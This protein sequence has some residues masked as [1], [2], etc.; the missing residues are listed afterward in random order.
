[1]VEQ[2]KTVFLQSLIVTIVIFTIGLVIGFAIE[3]SRIDRTEIALLNSEINLLD[4]QVRNLNIETFNVSCD[5]AIQS[6]FDFADRIYHEAR[7]L[8]EYDLS[9]KFTNEL[10]VIHKKYDLLR[11]ILWAHTIETKEMCPHRYHTIVYLF[12]YN[13]ENINQKARQAAMSRLLLDLKEKYGMS[14][15]LI[16]IASNLDLES[17]ELIKTRYKISEVPAI[18]IDEKKV[19]SK[20]ITLAELEDIVFE[21]NDYEIYSGVIYEEI[22]L[23]N[24]EKIILNLN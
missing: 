9:S 19:V 5:I 15:L 2:S 3:S 18:I 24:P 7:L 23:S 20:E 13:S 22:S 16:P 4:E 17:I 14:I 6:T 10:E 8:E 21:Q 11:A 12:N 1:M